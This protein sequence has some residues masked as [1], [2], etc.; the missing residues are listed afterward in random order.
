MSLLL[1]GETGDV[2]S[3]GFF[4]FPSLSFLDFEEEEV[5]GGMELLLKHA[6]AGFVEFMQ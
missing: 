3:S 6:K 1:D 5:F 4:T 2:G